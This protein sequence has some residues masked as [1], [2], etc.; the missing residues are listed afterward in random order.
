VHLSLHA[1]LVRV[2]GMRQVQQQI[3]CGG[4]DRGMAWDR[5][6]SM[7]MPWCPLMAAMASMISPAVLTWPCPTSRVSISNST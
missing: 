3:Q 5:P 2:R 1:H 4:F 6:Q 7:S